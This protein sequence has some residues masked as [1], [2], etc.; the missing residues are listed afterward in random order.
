MLKISFLIQYQMTIIC[1][2]KTQFELTPEKH[3]Q[4]LT[5][6]NRHIWSYIFQSIDS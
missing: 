1:N 6:L 3:P 5:I 2:G 4:H